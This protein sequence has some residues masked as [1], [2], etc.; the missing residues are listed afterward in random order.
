MLI[1]KIN[2]TKLKNSLG[3]LY[4]MFTFHRLCFQASLAIAVSCG[5]FCAAE[6]TQSPQGQAETTQAAEPD[7][8]K[9]SEAFGHFIGRNLKSSGLNFDIDSF[10][11]GIRNGESDKPSPMSDK[12]YERQMMLLQEKAFKRLADENLKAAEDFLKQNATA[13]DVK[14]ITPSKL[15][16]TILE[17]GHG[18]AVTEHSSPKI[19]YVGK[20]LD[21]TS[22]G[23]SRD[24][25]GPI[26]IPLDQTIPGFSQGLIGMKEGEKRKLFVHPDLG[27]GKTGH[28]PPNSL[29]IFEVEVLEAT[30]SDKAGADLDED[31]LSEIYGNESKDQ[32]DDEDDEDDEDASSQDSKA[33]KKS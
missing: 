30:S 22:F 17:E 15:Q 23:N 6:G 8:K 13:Q 27:Y 28:L 11:L 12:E 10:I 18:P 24:T 19:H 9:L 26:T 31:D 16:Y 33:S 21:G 32:D 14:E 3:G 2:R 25:G 29:L 7:I 5:S 4:F 1:D 20:Y